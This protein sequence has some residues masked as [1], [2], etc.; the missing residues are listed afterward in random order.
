MPLTHYDQELEKLPDTYK[1]AS[2]VDIT[3]LRA[4]IAGASESSIIGV[5][6]GGSYTVASL[7]CNLHETYT[8][9]V[10][11]PATSLEIICNPTLASSSPVFLISAEGKNPDIVEALQRARRHS[12]RPIHVI[13]N[14]P[15]S[16]LM[17]A[18]RDL[19][20]LTAHVFEL[21]EKDGYLATNSL[22]LN[23]VLVA[24][25]YGE[26]A[27]QADPAPGLFSSLTLRGQSIEGWL[28]EAQDFIAA[29]ANRGN[30]IVTYSPLLSPIA[31]DLESKLAEA[32]LLHCQLADLR[33]LAHGR[34]LWFAQ[35]PNECAV[36]ALVEPSLEVL[37]AEMQTLLP[38]GLPTYTMHFSSATPRDL[39]AGLVAEM[40]LVSAIAN[41]RNRDVGRPDVPAFGRALYYL[42]LPKMIPRPTE[43]S[44]H[45]EQ[46]KYSVLG[47]R[48]PTVV[49]QDSMQRALSASKA[50]LEG[51]TFRAI[52]FDYDGT[53]C[54]SQRDDSPPPARVVTHLIRLLE[55]N[56]VVGVASGRG[57]SVQ[58]QLQPSLPK[59]LWNLVELALYNG[60]LMT[61]L[62]DS[63]RPEPETSEYLSHVE[64]IVRRLQGL[65]VPIDRVRT[66]HPHQVSVRF[67][68]GLHTDAMWFVIADALRGA[69]LDPALMVKSKH[70]VDVLAPTVDKSH[71]I[72]TLVHKHAIKPYEVLAFGDQ[73]AWPG[74]DFSLLEHKFSLSVDVP[75]RRLD[76]GWKLAPSHKRD[77]DAT[78]WYLDR[79]Q[80]VGNGSFRLRFDSDASEIA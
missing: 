60:G 53:L 3:R 33:S 72:A 11:R 64:R 4:A 9:R 17:A 32:A 57:G 63:A 46:S 8:G 23:A 36:L 51:Q 58:E 20:E 56:V 18:V 77:V 21:T 37:W 26:L 34:H 76:R 75:S 6:T 12:A 25:G 10:S 22:L 70:S 19:S 5:G 2:T 43:T 28:A 14:K 45:A 55:G 47:A 62:G 30:V 80:L 27:Q 31:A 7:L 68:E 29:V 49:R 41:V 65:G 24:R 66:S 52:V 59:P 16:N 42:D 61:S 1:R 78:V 50:S 71:L 67:R 40:H 73:G 39:I 69:G 79:M 15:D 74:N 54:T 48:W 38:P 13:S 35:R 44:A